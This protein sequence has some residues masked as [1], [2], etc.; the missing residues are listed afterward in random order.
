MAKG[1]Q[2]EGDAVRA[3]ATYASLGNTP[4]ANKYINDLQRAIIKRKNSEAKY[5]RENYDRALNE[6]DLSRLER[7]W[8]SSPE[9]SRSIFDY[10]EMKKWSNV[11]A[12]PGAGSPSVATKVWN[13]ATGKVEAR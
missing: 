9:A 4:Q 5:Y 11:K 6:G 7:D 1:V 2:A 13:P 3:K 8:M 10:P 12:A